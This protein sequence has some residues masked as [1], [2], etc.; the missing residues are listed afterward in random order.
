MG[1]TLSSC[2]REGK[3]GFVIKHLEIMRKQLLEDI[4]ELSS[5]VRQDEKRIVGNRITI[6]NYQDKVKEIDEAIKKLK[7]VK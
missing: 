5:C 1:G 7:K 2:N 6:K 4:L 3:M